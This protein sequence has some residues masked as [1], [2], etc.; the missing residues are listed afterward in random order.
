MSDNP[1]R[2]PSVTVADPV[3]RE[4]SL[5]LTAPRKLPAER[6]WG[7]IR[8]S[9]RFFGDSPAIWIVNVIILVVI[10]MLFG[11]IPFLGGI[12]SSILSPVFGAGLMLGCAAQDRGEAL[13]V[14]HLFAGF[15]KNVGT[16]VTVGVLYLLG[17]IVIFIIVGLITVGLGGGG[18]GIGT[19][20]GAPTPEDIQNLMPV[21]GMAVLIALALF[22]P[23]IMA[24][25]FA[26]ALVVFHDLGAV[27]AM[28]LSFRGCLRNVLPFLVYGLIAFVL[29]VVA[30]IPF[31]LGWLVLGPI[32]IATIY[33]SYREVFTEH[34]KEGAAG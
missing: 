21:L 19:M 16:L 25:W 17:S 4:A 30:T 28:K 9:F 7:W 14:D 15:Q 23:L 6:G 31:F 22:I 1:Y 34:A 12:A 11:L 5:V 8:E 27:E 10:M 18:I 2:P 29:A 26:P 24:Y 32:L 3:S 13:R 33:V 20:L